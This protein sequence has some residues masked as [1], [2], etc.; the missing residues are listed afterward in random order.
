[1]RAKIKII[2]EVNIVVSGLDT[3]D[4]MALSDMFAVYTKGYRHSAK[5]K[6]GAWDGKIKFFHGNGKSYVK[7]L[8][9]IV[10]Y[11]SRADYTI[12][13]DDRRVTVDLTIDEIDKNYLK[14]KGYDVVLGPHQVRGVNALIS[15]AGG[16]FEGG[17]GAGKTLMTAVL[18]HLYEENLKFKCI[19]I[20][21]TSD[22]IDQTKEELVKYGVDVGEYS[23]TM[24]D[25]NHT[26]VVSTWQALQNNKGI[27]G[28]FQTVIVDECH[29][30]AGATLQEILNDFGAN[31]LIRLGLTGTLPEADIDMMA[32][33]I[34]LGHVVETVEASELIS[35][36]WLAE[37]NLYTY[38]LS[39]DVR[40]DYHK[41]CEEY[42]EEAANIT[43]KEYKDKF[44]ADYQSEKKYI[45]KRPER[46]EFLSKIIQKPTKNTLVLV[47]NVD[48]GRALAKMIPNAVFIYGKDVKAVRKILYSSFDDKDDIIAIT[49]FQLASTGLNIKRI[50]NLFLID[51]GKS[52]VQVIQ[53]IGRGLRKAHDKD[54]VNVYD[55]YS[56]FKFSKRHATARKKHYKTKKYPFKASK[57]DYLPLVQKAT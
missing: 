36:G 50:F 47:P 49:T 45:Q 55:V 10:R 22:L 46:L 9:E 26:H 14:D 32:V 25:I 18:C 54:K 43:Y 28:N 24:K 7:L 1:M 56:D 6:I 16:I 29:G 51:A 38:E 4:I 5:Y 20:V 13:I 37:L 8:P 31:C 53:S 57:V 48:F 41:F 23:G 12:D 21:P 40:D 19:V 35:N 39:E 3:R 11:L 33:R 30:V 44:F 52:Y 42:P 2:D 17:T 34:T 27:V 15:E